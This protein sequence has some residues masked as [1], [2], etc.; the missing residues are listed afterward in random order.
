MISDFVYYRLYCFSFG[1]RN[2]MYIE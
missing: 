1:N 2:S